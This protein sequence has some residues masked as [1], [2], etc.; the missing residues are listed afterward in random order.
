MVVWCVVMRVYDN[1]PLLKG[2]SLIFYL[3]DLTNRLGHNGTPHG[4]GTRSLGH[5]GSHSWLLGDFLAGS[6]LTS[7]W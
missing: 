1:A 4:L 3:W 6:W 2:F 7:D 5:L